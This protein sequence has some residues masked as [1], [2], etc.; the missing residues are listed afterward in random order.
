MR[1]SRPVVAVLWSATPNAFTLAPGGH[2]GGNVAATN[3][4][5]APG[6]VP[7]PGCPVLVGHPPVLLPRTLCP[8]TG[9]TPVVAAHK[10]KR[11]Q[12]GW[13][14]TSD[15]TRTGTPLPAGAYTIKIG[16]A[17]VPITVA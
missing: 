6:T 4:D 9:R 5:T 16:G 1:T 14:A 2:A 12:W 10:Q 13:N 8:P 3:L 7:S 15:G 17:T 11:W